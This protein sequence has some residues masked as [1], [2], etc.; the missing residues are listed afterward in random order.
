MFITLQDAC[1]QFD[2]VK[3]FIQFSEFNALIGVR[4]S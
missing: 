4:E 2:T 3:F 1:L